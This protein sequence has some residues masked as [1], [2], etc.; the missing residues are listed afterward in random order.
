MKKI[1][2]IGLMLLLTCV[3]L[4]IATPV[5]AQPPGSL[6]I[7]NVSLLA[8]D[9]NFTFDNPAAE[10]PTAYLVNN[11]GPVNLD[12]PS[13]QHATPGYTWI[14]GTV[15][16]TTYN[17]EVVSYPLKTYDMSFHNYTCPKSDPELTANAMLLY[18]YGLWK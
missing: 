4:T 6:T 13:W 14:S 7:S 18:A 12:L 9:M 5:V 8:Q 2:I 10:M 17:S 16:S 11:T 15:T 1:T 3:V